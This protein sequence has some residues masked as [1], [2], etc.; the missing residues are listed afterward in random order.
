M[1]TGKK[2]LSLTTTPYGYGR[3]NAVVFVIILLFYTSDQLTIL[4]LVKVKFLLLNTSLGKRNVKDQRI[5]KKH[6]IG[7]KQEIPIF[8][9][10]IF[11]HIRLIIILILYYI[12]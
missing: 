7:R 1:P 3:T 8:I 5:L 2:R 10:S 6:F 11:Y 4:Y 9:W 12:T